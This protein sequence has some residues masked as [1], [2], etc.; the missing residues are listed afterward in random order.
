MTETHSVVI[1]DTVHVY[2]TL[3]DAAQAYITAREACCGV[4]VSARKEVKT[5]AM[6]LVYGSNQ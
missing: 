2:E 5:R 1:N 6:E 4:N 3:N